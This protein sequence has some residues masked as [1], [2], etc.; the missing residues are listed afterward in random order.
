MKIRTIVISVVVSAALVAGAGYGAYYTMQSKKTPIEVVPV[1]NVNNGGY[2]GMSD[3]IYGTVT[4]QIAQNITLDEEYALAEIYVEEGQQVKEGTPLFAYDMTLQELELEMEKLNQQVYEL[5]MTKLE[6]DL[7][8][9]Q[10]TPATASLELNSFSM[11]TASNETLIIEETDP[12]ENTDGGDAPSGEQN[13]GEEQTEFIDKPEQTGTETLQPADEV[14]VENIEA[15]D[16]DPKEQERLA[17]LDCVTTYEK[18]VAAIDSLFKAYGEELVSSDVEEAIQEAVDYYQKH[19]AEEKTET[20]VDDEGNESEQTTYVLRAEV[21]AAL[22]EAQTAELE[23]YTA[24][25]DTYRMKCEEMK[26]AETAAMELAQSGAEEASEQQTETLPSED[27][28]EQQSE[29]ASESE[30]EKYYTVQVAVPGSANTASAAAG[31]TIVVHTDETVTGAMFVG[32]TVRSADDGSELDPKLLN[33]FDPEQIDT[34]FVMPA[35]NLLLVPNYQIVPSE[36]EG[37]LSSFEE[38]AAK[39]LA[40][41]AEQQENYVT[42]LGDAAAYY[43]Q[44]LADP[45]SEILDDT[46]AAPVMEQYQLKTEIAD[47]LREQ[48]RENDIEKLAHEYEQLCKD[49]V[50]TLIL[51]LNP[52]ALIRSEWEAASEAYQSLGDGWR[53]QLEDAWM[54]EQQ[55]KADAE[56]EAAQQPEQET[57]DETGDETTQTEAQTTARFSLGE[58]LQ[59]YEM[60]LVIQELDL[61][62]QEELLQADLTAAY[63]KYLALTDAQ[64]KAVWNAS[65]LIDALKARNMWETEPE[66]DFAGADDGFGD[67]GGYDGDMGSYTAAELKELIE[68]KEREIKECALSIREAELAVKKAQR[69][70]DGKIVKSTLDGT[71][72]SIGTLE[73]NSDDEYF[74]KVTNTEGLYAKGSMNELELERIHVGDTIS[75]MMMDT[76]V[77]F[78]AVIKE[79]SAYP[80]ADNESMYYFSSDSENTNASYYPFYALLEDTTDIE[81]GEAEIQLA[82]TMTNVNDIICLEKY[83]VRTDNAGKSYV[84]ISDENGKLKKQYVTVGKLIYGYALEI[85]SGLE[86]TDKIAFPY[87]EDVFEGAATKEVDLLFQ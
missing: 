75:G 22:G 4:S 6:K 24:L 27:Q 28:T 19:L 29:S 53:A 11:T 2:W 70:V 73:G 40:E 44:W 59:I 7:E 76:G 58:M 86:L 47:Y 23:T 84:Y 20:V 31:D 33:G 5:T 10:K 60:I 57:E 63:G 49:Y 55:T 83:F 34:T 38:L 41:G 32:W 30:T 67:D 36:M 87:G 21:T 68:D 65:V 51:K 69:V 14:Q 52:Q 35:V 3:S 71:V 85:L 37:L 25:L 61:N 72:V 66:T 74:A 54:Q 64:K 56:T 81:E 42:M 39:A 79:I 46:A 9:L 62:S 13:T 80:S 18:V 77:S 82:E 78:T 48:N 12:S 17:I 45:A 43:Q 1:S 26:Q 15:V 8:K 50:K 16:D